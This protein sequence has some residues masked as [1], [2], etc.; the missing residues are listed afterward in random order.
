MRDA[1]DK[2]EAE[3]NAAVAVAGTG[4]EAGAAADGLE[5]CTRAVRNSGDELISTEAA[6][7]NPHSKQEAELN[8]HPV[9][10]KVYTVQG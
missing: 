7:Q 6:L 3:K 1:L 10:F 9:S 5:N 2:H 4:A 8:D